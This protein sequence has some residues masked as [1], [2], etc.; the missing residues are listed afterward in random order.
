MLVSSC[1]KGALGLLVVPHLHDFIDTLSEPVRHALLAGAAERRFAKGQM[2]YNHGDPATDLYQLVAGSVR[3]FNI[4]YDGKEVVFCDFRP[5]DCFGEMGVIDGLPRAIN[6]TALEASTALVISKAHFQAQ[7]EKYPEI[8]HRLAVMLSLRVR[9]LFEMTQDASALSLHQRLVRVLHRLVYSHGV[10]GD[11]GEIRIGVS[12]EGLASMLGV[13]R[14]SVSKELQILKE[15][16]FIAIR[17]GK[18]HILNL[19]GLSDISESG[20]GG[21]QVAPLY[22]ERILPNFRAEPERVGL[23]QGMSGNST[24]ASRHCP[25]PSV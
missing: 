4:T 22:R 16:G 20:L 7:A 1:S 12:Q 15:M 24:R 3:L 18:L 14:Q 25:V 8:N 9:L 10:E 11:E 23:R 21:E 13:S 5:G 19:Q 17:Y 2:I 6:A